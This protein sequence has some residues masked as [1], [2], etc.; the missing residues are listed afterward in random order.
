M[1]DADT[2][3]GTGTR[4]KEQLELP[5]SREQKLSSLATFKARRSVLISPTTLGNLANLLEQIELSVGEIDSD[6]FKHISRELLGGR[7]K[8]GISSVKR[9][10]SAAEELEILR[11]KRCRSAD[12]MRPENW[13]RVEWGSVARRGQMQITA[14]DTADGGTPSYASPSREE[15]DVQTHDPEAHT[16]AA[17][18][19][20]EPASE[21]TRERPDAEHRPPAKIGPLDG[22]I[23]PLDGPIG[24][25]DGPIFSSPN[26]KKVLQKDPKLSGPNL[27]G[28]QI[29]KGGAGGNG[30]AAR[31]GHF[32]L[33]VAVL[34]NADRLDEWFDWAVAAGVAVIHQKLQVFATARSVFRRRTGLEN[35]PGAF[36]SIVRKKLW[37]K[38]D[39]RTK[40]PKEIY[41]QAD[42][43]WARLELR[44]IAGELVE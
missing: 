40:R 14:W 17:G 5:L 43:D 15:Q 24:P 19:V 32:V 7:L 34:A 6:G 38:I 29:P 20:N 28:P 37:G 4:P 44:R 9:W 10:T 22:P 42:E 33:S 18:D 25:L 31:A 12:G 27:C 16:N 1:M 11:V 23:G 26:P 41:S 30:S 21:S 39:P 3:T 8:V 36:Y 35:P 2:G 13:W